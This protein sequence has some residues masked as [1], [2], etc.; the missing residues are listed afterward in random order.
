MF[1]QLDVVLDTASPAIIFIHLSL[2]TEITGAELAVVVVVVVISPSLLVVLLQQNQ[3]NSNNKS[4][5]SELQVKLVQ[6]SNQPLI[7][8]HAGQQVL[9]MSLPPGKSLTLI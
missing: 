9:R 2:N 6:L 1:G 4:A 3:R 7:C 5:S 8:K